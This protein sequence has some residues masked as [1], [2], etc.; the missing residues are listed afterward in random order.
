MNGA[1]RRAGDD[2]G[3]TQRVGIR[4]RRPAD[5]LLGVVAPFAEPLRVVR[6]RLASPGPPLRVIRMPDRR[7]TP[8]RAAPL[9]AGDD[10]VADRAGE[11]AALGVNG[12]D[13]VGHRVGEQAAHPHGGAPAGR[14]VEPPA[15][16]RGRDRPVTLQVRGRVVTAVIGCADEAG[17]GD[18]DADLEGD[19]GGARL[20]GDPLHEGV[21]LDLVAAALVADR[22]GCGRGVVQGLEDRNGFLGRQQCGEVGHR[23]G[24]GAHGDPA[25]ARGVGCAFDIGPRVKLIGQRPCGCV[26]LSIGHGVQATGQALIQLAAPG[27]VE[28]DGRLDD[29]GGAPLTDP[30]FGEGGEGV[31]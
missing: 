1:R 2:D 29:E 16:V 21:G 10:E 18:D 17:V 25:F 7:P 19:C 6:C 8:G 3:L 12:G 15:H 27:L 4:G 31:R 28:G 26:G 9:V 20:A 11:A 14:L 5:R 22:A 23:V 30:T 13:D 24:C